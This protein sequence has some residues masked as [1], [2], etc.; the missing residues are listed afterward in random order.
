MVILAVIQMLISWSRCLFQSRHML[1]P[2]H[3]WTKHFFNSSVLQLL[4]LWVVQCKEAFGNENYHFV[5]TSSSSSF[6]C[7]SALWIWGWPLAFSQNESVLGNSYPADTLGTSCTRRLG[8]PC[9]CFSWH[10]KEEVP[11]PTYNW[12]SKRSRRQHISWLM[13]SIDCVGLA[14]D[15]VTGSAKQ[16]LNQALQLSE[17]G[18]QLQRGSRLH[19]HGLPARRPCRAR[20]QGSSTRLQ[21]NY[22][23]GAI[24]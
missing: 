23:F 24:V 12:T 8:F 10:P 14:S 2:K 11:Y 18:H 9:A 21:A 7:S 15:L 22:K 17:V 3:F 16:T 13:Q 5:S 1:N 19:W 6:G 4:L 20:D